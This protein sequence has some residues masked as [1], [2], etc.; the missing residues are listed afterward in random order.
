LAGWR[1]F[2]LLGG[3]R[4]E[5]ERFEKGDWESHGLKMGKV[6]DNQLFKEPDS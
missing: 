3:G 4:K 5:I 1:R 6:K 2:T